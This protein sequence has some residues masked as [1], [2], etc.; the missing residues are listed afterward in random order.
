[1]C[2]SDWYVPTGRR[3]TVLSLV[4]AG[5]SLGYVIAALISGIVISSWGWRPLFF[6]AAIPGLICLVLMYG[7]SDPPVWLAARQRFKQDGRNE[8]GAIWKDMR[9]RR[10]FLL[11]A[12]TSIALQ[13]GYYGANTWLPSYLVRDLHVSLKKMGWF[14]ASSYAM[15]ILSKP[16]IGFLADR[17]GR[18]LMWIIS[19]SCITVA[20]PVILVIATG[21]N[22]AFLLLIFGGLYGALYAINATYLSE[23]FPTAVR[24]TAMAT[25]YNVGRIGSMI[26]PVFIGWVATGG[27][28]GVGIASCAVAYLAA[29]LLPGIFIGEKMHDPMELGKNP[30]T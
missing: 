12:A 2:I 28:I 8:F 14:L 21:S 27:S 13:F 11:W 23:S 15:G 16:I 3:N 7:V 9:L 30:G 25:S 17:F 29:T 18:R 26:A 19:G 4:M 5:W 1:M 6:L 24:G 20:I 22:V 10:T